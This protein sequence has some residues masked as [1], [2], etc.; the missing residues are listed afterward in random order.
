MVNSV[1]LFGWINL[2]KTFFRTLSL[3][4]IFR[5]I[6]L[7][8]SFIQKFL[9]EL[10]LL[11]VLQRKLFL[12]LHLCH[13][14]L[15]DSL[16]TYGA[17]FLSLKKLINCILSLLKGIMMIKRFCIRVV[18]NEFSSARSF[19]SIETYFPGHIQEN[20]RSII[21]NPFSSFVFIQSPL[22]PFSWINS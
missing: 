18:W 9:T 15:L 19:L 13:A 21:T 5:Y 14:R 7:D 8:L 20:S 16:K 12:W 17:N 2:H 22:N 6:S 4:K 3:S 1:T 10:S 11:H